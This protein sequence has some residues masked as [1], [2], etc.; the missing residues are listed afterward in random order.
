VAS[1]QHSPPS[2]STRTS[3]HEGGG[4]ARSP[5]P[6]RPSSTLLLRAQPWTRA[7][8]GCLDHDR[9]GFNYRLDTCPARSRGADGSARR[10]ARGTRAGPPGSTRFAR[11]RRSARPALVPTPGVDAASPVRGRLPA[12][13]G[14]DLPRDA[15]VFSM[16]EAR[17]TRRSALTALDP[18]DEASTASASPSRGRVPGLR[19][20]GAALA[21]APFFGYAGRGRIVAVAGR[22]AR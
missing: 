3:N 12:P 2:P 13:P 5:V 20:R 22:C 16:H 6:T 7:D 17:G 9:L 18:P 11:G 19:G 15:A 1:R 14:V 8:M 10:A 4:G 21:P